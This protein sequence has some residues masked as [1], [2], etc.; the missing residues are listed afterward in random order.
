MKNQNLFF[1]LSCAW[2]LPRTVSHINLIEQ[3]FE[4]L[5]LAACNRQRGGGE[6]W[7]RVGEGIPEGQQREDG[8]QFTRTPD[9]GPDNQSIT[10]LLCASSLET[11][12]IAIWNMQK[13]TPASVAPACSN[14]SASDRAPESA[15][16]DFCSWFVLLGCQTTGKQYAC[17]FFHSFVMLLKTEAAL[18]FS[19][20]CTRM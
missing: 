9:S 4:I 18:L 20:S 13:S 3:K 7:M 16:R 17:L 11:N 5:T 8:W 14:P 10:V 19:K 1:A 12:A 6:L 15:D 2:S